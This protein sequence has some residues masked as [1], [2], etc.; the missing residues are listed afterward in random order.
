MY[1]N[2]IFLYGTVFG[3]YFT[4]ASLTNFF[5]GGEWRRALPECR[6]SYTS[7]F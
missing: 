3:Y 2:K 7:R 6:I 5:Y 1:K 4:S